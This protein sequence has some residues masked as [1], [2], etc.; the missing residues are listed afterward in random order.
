MFVKLCS[1]VVMIL[2]KLCIVMVCSIVLWLNS[3]GYWLSF[4]SVLCLSVFRKLCV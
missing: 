4:V 2:L 3:F 1:G